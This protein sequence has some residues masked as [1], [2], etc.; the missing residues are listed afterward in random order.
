M[1]GNGAETLGPVVE[2]GDQFF[3]VLR[4]LEYS[5]MYGVVNA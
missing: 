1:G 2:A 5:M 3:Q 4:H